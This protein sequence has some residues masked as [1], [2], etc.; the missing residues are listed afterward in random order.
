MAHNEDQV[1]V[2]QEKVTLL[3]ISTMKKSNMCL[4]CFLQHVLNYVNVLIIQFNLWITEEELYLCLFQT[5]EIMLCLKNKQ[6]KK[7]NLGL[8]ECLGSFSTEKK[9]NDILFCG[10][11]KYKLFMNR[12]NQHCF[13]LG[14]QTRTFYKPKVIQFSQPTE[15]YVIL[16]LEFRHQKRRFLSSGN[17]EYNGLCKAQSC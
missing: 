17:I 12:E 14:H 3:K 7:N 8:K 1:F 5:K 4:I 9:R 6:T 13:Q 16:Q 11:P 10:P 15:K 2:I